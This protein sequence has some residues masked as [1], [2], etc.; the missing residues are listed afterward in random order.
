[1]L[2]VRQVIEIS[3]ITDDRD[4]CFRSFRALLFKDR[5]AKLPRRENNCVCC[6]AVLDRSPVKALSA[7]PDSNVTLKKLN[8]VRIMLEIHCLT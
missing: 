2:H 5:N 1:M 7:V 8:N 6:I 4:E 3:I